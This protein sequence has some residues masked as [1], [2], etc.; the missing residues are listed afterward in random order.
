M[1]SH[2]EISRRGFT[3]ML[4]KLAPATAFGSAAV[5][6]LALTEQTA[7]HPDARLIELAREYAAAGLAWRDADEARADTQRRARA[8]YPQPPAIIMFKYFGEPPTR[9]MTE[10]EI[11]ELS[12]IELLAPSQPKRIAA[13]KKY[14]AECQQID[15]VMG[16]PAAIQADDE[17]GR[18]YAR[19]GRLIVDTPAQTGV[20]LYIKLAVEHC[21]VTPENAANNAGEFTGDIMRNLIA[22]NMATD[23][24]A[25]REAAAALSP[26]LR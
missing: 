4:A 20:G 2:N 1:N 17:A 9:V 23:S 18:E 19:L 7:G 14:K 6:A 12:H 24:G 21:A 10:E 22:M 15:D 26:Y 13:F 25:Q 8:Q 11:E 16:V 3:G 5:P